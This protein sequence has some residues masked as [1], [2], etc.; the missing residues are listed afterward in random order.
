MFD[1]FSRDLFSDKINHLACFLKTT[2]NH[3]RS[4][5][6]AEVTG[7]L[8]AALAEVQAGGEPVSGVDVWIVALLEDFLHLLHLERRERD[9]GLPLF[10]PSC[11]QS[12]V[13]TSDQQFA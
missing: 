13:I 2:V 6:R 8:Y 3:W 7:Y 9:P 10:P 11:N 4:R 5:L 12:T 1:H